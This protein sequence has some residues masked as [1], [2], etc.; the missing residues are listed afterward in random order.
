MQLS[1]RTQKGA[2]QMIYTVAFQKGG[3]GKTSTAHAIAAGATSRG[4]KA[5]AIDLDPQGNL[6][7][8][9]GGTPAAAGAYGII[10]GRD[11]AENVIQH[12]EQGDII[13]AGLNLSAV[14][15][16]IGGRPGRDFLL[17]AA[18]KPIAARY[19]VVVIDT[20]PALGTLLVNA[21]TAA[22]RAILTMNADIY[23]LQGLYLLSDTI[24]QVQTYCN[25]TLS[26]E[27]VL[28]TRYSNRT[29][30]ARDMTTSTAA[31]LEHLGIKLFRTVIREGV[32]VKEAAALQRSLYE[33]APKSNPARDYSA[34]LDELGI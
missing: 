1:Q 18:I 21:L 2:N 15:A 28:F 16:E 27:G 17:Q 10:T 26:V 4:K 7:Y 8:A 25:P 19:D 13:P 14:D 23:S 20:P 30:L 29:S 32:A 12:T 34:F 3:T 11:N 6:T 31:A 9:M 33:Y 24:K 22:D 5:L